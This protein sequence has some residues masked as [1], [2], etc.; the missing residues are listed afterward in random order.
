MGTTNE[1][2][3]GTAIPLGGT[4]RVYMKQ[5]TFDFA[6]ENHASG[7]VLQLITVPAKTWV[8]G[9][10][11]EVETAEGGTLTFDVGDGA[12]VDGFIDGADGNALANDLPLINEAFSPAVGGKYYASEDTLD[13]TI[14]NAADA[15]KITIRA[16]MI[17]LSGY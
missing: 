8:L 9:V 16:V 6:V 12:T 7:D 2:Q 4:D 3:G 14:N 1:T 10:Q 17:D 13:M 5:R 11:Y 15:A